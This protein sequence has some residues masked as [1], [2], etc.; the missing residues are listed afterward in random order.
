M[1]KKKKEM[2]P[3]MS[4]C[5]KVVRNGVILSGLYFGSLWATSELL[6][7]ASL[8]PLAI[9]FIGYVFAEL[10]K[11]Y[12]LSLTTPTKLKVRS[13]KMLIF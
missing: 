3:E 2:N 11:R 10:A 8:K 5:L 13:T 7:W 4:F 1:V 12:G 6:T 9:F